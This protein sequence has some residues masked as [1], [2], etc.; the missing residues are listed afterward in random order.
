MKKVTVVVAVSLVMTIAVS[1]PAATPVN[2]LTRG[3]VEG[4]WSFTT[5]DPCHVSESFIGNGRGG[6]GNALSF[7]NS[8]FDWNQTALRFVSGNGISLPAN[9]IPN[10]ST[11]YVGAWVKVTSGFV[12]GDTAGEINSGVEVYL[13]LSEG[14][15]EG[16]YQSISDIYNNTHLIN[17]LTFGF[18]E[19]NSVPIANLTTSWQYFEYPVHVG[20][21]GSPSGWGYVELNVSDRVGW[22]GDLAAAFTGTI[23]LDDIYLGI[24]SQ[25]PE[26]ANPQ[27]CG[28]YGTVYLAADLNHDCY[29]NFK[30]MAKLAQNWIK[31]TNP[32]DAA[33]NQ[34][35]K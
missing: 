32:A 30:D 7:T 31:C 28:D 34:Y 20:D 25:K 9:R 6:Y 15:T 12:L 23:Y 8:T 17:S 10:N 19:A 18:A 26:L 27:I 16:I 35:W 3:D 2:L 14:A 11:V 21:S 4:G 33:C 24:M 1:V 5:H 29:I 13:R 22:R